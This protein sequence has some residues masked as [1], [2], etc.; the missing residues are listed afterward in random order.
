MGIYRRRGRFSQL[1]RMAWRYY[2]VE[3][4]NCS[5]QLLTSNPFG[6]VKSG[7]LVLKGRLASA[8]PIDISSNRPYLNL[9]KEILSEL[10]IF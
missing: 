10:S 9:P 6:Q 4:I 5:V 7:S 8:R 3:V 1:D 2:V